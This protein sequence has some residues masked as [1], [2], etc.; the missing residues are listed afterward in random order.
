MPAPLREFTELTNTFDLPGVG[1]DMHF[2]HHEYEDGGVLTS[3]KLDADIEVATPDTGESTTLFFNREE[4]RANGAATISDLE[5]VR[6]DIGKNNYARTQYRIVG[7]EVMRDVEC[8]VLDEEG[9]AEGGRIIGDLTSR[10]ATK[11]TAAALI[12]MAR[13]E[14]EKLSRESQKES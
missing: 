10:K 4:I 3:A 13:I 2:K 1:L 7:D 6:I 8:Q 9:S 14:F 11:H 5:F 12:R